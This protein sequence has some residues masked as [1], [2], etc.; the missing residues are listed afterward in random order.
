MKLT[1]PAIALP[2]FA[3]IASVN[4]NGV[5]KC[6]MTTMIDRSASLSLYALW[7]ATYKLFAKSTASPAP[8]AVTP[9]ITM[10]CRPIILS[11]QS[12]SAWRD[13]RNGA[14]EL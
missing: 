11:I 2:Y 14:P 1:I 8:L 4:A 5:A 7:F 13:A 10:R 3:H 12:S 9:S 6:R